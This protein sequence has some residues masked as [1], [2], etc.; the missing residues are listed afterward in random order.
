M[1]Y[2]MSEQINN[3]CNPIVRGSRWSS[4]VKM[5]SVNNRS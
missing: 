1:L 5:S 3:N 4:I 2:E